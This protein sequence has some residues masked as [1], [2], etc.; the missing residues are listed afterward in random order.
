MMMTRMVWLRI[1]AIASGIAGLI[2]SACWLHDP[3]GVFWETIFSLVNV[4]QLAVIKYR[5]FVARFSEDDRDFYNRIFPK[6]EPH[7]M[8]RLLKTGKWLTAPAGTQ[9]TRQ[10]EVVP[11]LCSLHSGCLEVQVNGF[12]IGVCDPKILIGEISNWQR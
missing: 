10:A 6:L 9:L 4:V 2:Y 1:L 5:N 11:H 3:V 12:P 7:Q 8:H